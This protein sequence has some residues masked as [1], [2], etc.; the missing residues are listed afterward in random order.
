MCSSGHAL[1]MI[2]NTQFTKQKLLISIVMLFLSISNPLHA[3]ASY[4]E[5]FSGAPHPRA[6]GMGNAYVGAGTDLNSVFYNPAGLSYIKDVQVLSVYGNTLKDVN[7]TTVVVG[8]PLDKSGTSVVSL[9]YS[10]FGVVGLQIWE[11]GNVNPALVGSAQFNNSV[12][13]A[14]YANQTTDGLRYGVTAKAYRTALDVTSTGSG[15]GFGGQAVNMDAGLMFNFTKNIRMG[16][17]LQNLLEDQKVIYTTGSQE[18]L[19]RKAMIGIGTNIAG[20]ELDTPGEK[21]EILLGIDYEHPLIAGVPGLLHAGV[22]WWTNPNLAIRGGMDQVRTSLGAQGAY[23]VESRFTTGVGLRFNGIQLDYTY[24]PDFGTAS[25]TK[26]FLAVSYFGGDDPKR[27]AKK[28]PVKE[29][30]P[31]AKIGD[32]TI[33][34]AD[35]PDQ[36]KYRRGKDFAIEID[37]DPKSLATED[38]ETVIESR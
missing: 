31:V 4:S 34:V 14:S 8:L 26:H 30:A 18:T 9:G 36:L 6:M 25:D 11:S 27:V 35:D 19:Y 16:M 24:Y 38:Q 22:E 17:S 3:D 23:G 21:R 7:H 10:S 37:K 32:P 5:P 1:F 33:S 2:H 20:N 15:Q 29:V 28:E 13:Y 12:F